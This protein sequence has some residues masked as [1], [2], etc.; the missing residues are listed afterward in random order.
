M[1]TAQDLEYHHGPNDD[2]TWAETYYIP[3]SVPEERLFAHV[4]VCVRPVLGSMAN[5]IR[6]H[7]AVS[8]TE[9]DLL[10]IDSQ[11]HLPAPERFSHIHGPNGL[12]VKAV[13]PASHATCGIS[14]PSRKHT[15][16]TCR[17]SRKRS[18]SR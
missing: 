1:I 4:Y 15:S 9:F 10:S 6:V 16:S 2:Y 12:S 13:R 18:V 17:A 7:G 3:I 5:D 14:A 11:F 8:A